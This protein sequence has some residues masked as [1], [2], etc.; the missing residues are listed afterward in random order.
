M[1]EAYNPTEL[2]EALNQL[3]HW[4]Y[5]AE[6]KALHRRLECGDFS[7]A[8]ELMMRIAIDAERADHHPEWCN[9]YNRID[10]WLTTH[11]AAGVSSR[12][13]ALATRIDAIIRS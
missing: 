7:E 1:I 11:D 13:E 12:D 2:A 4:R 6:R 8:M 3:P 9:V 5:D 10:I